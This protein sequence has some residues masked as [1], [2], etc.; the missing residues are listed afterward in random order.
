MV[1]NAK[2]NGNMKELFDDLHALGFHCGIYGTPWK[3][4]Y[5][6]YPGSS[7]DSHPWLQ[8]RPAIYIPNLFGWRCGN[9]KYEEQDAEYFAEIGADFCK[10][11]WYQ[12]DVD[13]TRRM[14]DA[15]RRQGRD[16]VY[17]LSNSAPIHNAKHYQQLSNMVRTTADIRDAW[18]T[19]APR[20]AYC[21]SIKEIWRQHEKWAPYNKPG[22]WTDP[23]M[24]VVGP[25]GW[26]ER[27]HHH[28][29]YHHDENA[30]NAEKSVEQPLY[31]SNLNHLTL[32]EQ[33]VHMT[34][35]ILWAA[36]LLIGC[37][38]EKIDND[39]LDLLCNRGALRI[40]EDRLG[41][42]GQTISRIVDAVVASKPLANGDVAVGLFNTGAGEGRLP[43]NVSW[44]ELGLDNDKKYSVHDVWAD[45]DLGLVQG[46]LGW[47]VR[48]HSA[49]LFRVSG[50]PSRK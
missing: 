39:T 24:L 14:H 32:D 12:N 20:D 44:N 35:W 33:L 18:D 43:V 42:Q 1:P 23:D 9:V 36:P 4:S 11:D 6:C 48:E 46:G 41:I 45:Q 37:D 16:I 50:K 26:G 47:G 40:N 10:W 8:S 27:D 21:L 49:K 17:S 2:F 31:K 38:L 29:L 7:E 5:A 13:S 19:H 25:V 15:L 3:Y 34:L 30:D 28:H 22:A